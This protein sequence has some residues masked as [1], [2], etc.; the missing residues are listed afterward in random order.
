MKQENPLIGYH[1]VDKNYRV[2]GPPGTQLDPAFGSQAQALAA[3]ERWG[4]RDRVGQVIPLFLKGLLGVL[5][6]GGDIV[7]DGAAALRLV[8]ASQTRGLQVKPGGGDQIVASAIE[9]VYSSRQVLGASAP[10]QLR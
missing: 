9:A 5:R 1:L 3:A 8:Q 4:C 7:L 6:Q 10:H 2:I